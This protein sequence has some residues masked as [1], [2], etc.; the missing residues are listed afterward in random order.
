[1]ELTTQLKAEIDAMDHECMWR[2]WRFAPV[3][4][5]IFQGESGKYFAEVMAKKRN[6]DPAGAVAASKAIGWERGD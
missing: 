4:E 3:G 1:M 2:E 5:G 6:A